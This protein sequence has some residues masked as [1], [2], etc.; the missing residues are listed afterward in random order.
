[1]N[2]ILPN[3]IKNSAQK[4]IKKLFNKPAYLFIFFFFINLII[5]FILFWQL[6]LFPAIDNKPQSLLVL[7]KNA[8]D[9]FVA[10]WEKQEEESSAIKNINYPDIFFGFS[11][12]KIQTTATSSSATTTQSK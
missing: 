10:D 8:L 6:V 3:S 4:A 1:M 5:A 12:P 9:R 7:N 2:T 11:S